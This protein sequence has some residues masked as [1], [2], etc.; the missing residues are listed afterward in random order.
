M[1]AS[2]RSN[3]GESEL[4]IEFVASAEYAAD[5]GFE[6]NVRLKAEHWDG[7]H[8]H[9]MSFSIDRLWLRKIDLDAMRDHIT[10]WIGRPLPQMV[11][12]LLDGTFHL[13]RLSA[14]ELTLRFGA[15][16]D[17]INSQNPVVSLEFGAG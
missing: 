10:T 7:D 4:V 1:E 2:L 6:A 17:T 12:T 11:P 9:P 5:A 8:T 14:Q 13:T 16:P 3:S 15:R